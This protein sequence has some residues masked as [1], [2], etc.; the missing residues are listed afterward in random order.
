[1]IV[2]LIRHSVK[3]QKIRHNLEKSYTKIAN[4]GHNRSV[5]FAVG[6]HVTVKVGRQFRSRHA[7]KRVFGVVVAVLR[8]S[9]YRIR[10]RFHYNAWKKLKICTNIYILWS[11][12]CSRG[13]IFTLK[14][15]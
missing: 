7:P 5:I 12:L 10:Y 11:N 14:G 6:D 13:R 2:Y 9:L 15:F 8:N 3:R 1:M 4:R